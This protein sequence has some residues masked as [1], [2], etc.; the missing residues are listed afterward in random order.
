MALQDD[1]R[2]LSRLPAFRDIEPDALR[3]VALSAET[4]ILRA[5]DVLFRQGD[6]SDGGYIVLS[7]KIALTSGQHPAVVVGPPILLG[8]A[9]LL[10]ETQRPATA[11]ARQPSSVLKVPRE[12]YRRVLTEYPD[13]AVRVRHDIAARLLAL[14]DD[15]D[16]LRVRLAG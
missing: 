4:R 3:L 7:G 11:Q 10:T 1:I 5:G 2:N 9:A 15:Y 6:P 13:S 16:D 14:Q 12:L 8:A